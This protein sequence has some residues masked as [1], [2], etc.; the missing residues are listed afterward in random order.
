MIKRIFWPDIY[1]KSVWDIDFKKIYKNGFRGLIFDIDNTIVG[2]DNFEIKKEIFD[3]F[4]E[5][6]EMGFKVCL[7]SNSFK[8]RVAYF[9]N[10]L[11]IKSFNTALKPLPFGIMKGIKYLGVPKNEIVMIGDQ[12]FT[13]V[14]C[15]R[16]NN[17]FIILVEPIKERIEFFD[18]FKRKLELKILNK[19]DKEK[20]K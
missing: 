12:I 13:D 8:R 6:E 17:I 19:Y 5:L 4:I 1:C 15:A 14:I 9:E 16:L 2:Y 7:V 20:K 11:N 3:L 18:R 10:V